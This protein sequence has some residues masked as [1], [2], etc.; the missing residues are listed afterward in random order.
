MD[1][2]LGG[3]KGMLPPPSQIIGGGAGPPSSY[4]YDLVSGSSKNSS[5]KSCGEHWCPVAGHC[6]INDQ[7]K[8]HMVKGID[9]A[10]DHME[11]CFVI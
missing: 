7:T 4:A 10:F 6:Q 2:L 9:N 1:G 11:L 3:P 8:F 5:S